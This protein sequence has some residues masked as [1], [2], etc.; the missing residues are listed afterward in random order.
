LLGVS[1][2]KG[3]DGEERSEL[4]SRRKGV[5]QGGRHGRLSLDVPDGRNG[6][7]IYEMT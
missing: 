5:I 1:A 3:S 7:P 6:I 4:G 2:A